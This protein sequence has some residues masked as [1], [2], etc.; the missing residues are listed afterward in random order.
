MWWLHDDERKQGV[1]VAAVFALVRVTGVVIAVALRVAGAVRA[2]DVLGELLGPVVRRGG[3][4]TAG[5]RNV[6]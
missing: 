6:I 5:Q 1:I 3:A 4:R 2:P